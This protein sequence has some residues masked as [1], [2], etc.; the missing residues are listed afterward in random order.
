MADNSSY[1]EKAGRN[2]APHS[3]ELRRLLRFR[4]KDGQIWLGEHRAVLLHADY[5][6]G[7]RRELIDTLGRTRAAGALFRMGFASGKADAA[8][9]RSLLPDAPLTDIMRLGPDMHGLEGL[10]VGRVDRLE[11]DL[12]VSHLV[13]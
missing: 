8:L 3:A 13:V 10:V 12:I 4:Q 7:L 6:R 11:M 1:H 5:L 2:D 9:V